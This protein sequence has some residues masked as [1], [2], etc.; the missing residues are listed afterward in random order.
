MR[1]CVCVCV[2][3]FQLKLSITGAEVVAQMGL[4]NGTYGVR[5]GNVGFR[6]RLED[7]C[8]WGDNIKMNLQG[9]ERG[10]GLD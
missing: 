2:R 9:I 10:P 8:R 1:V 3:A 5:C 7:M 4:R 6:S